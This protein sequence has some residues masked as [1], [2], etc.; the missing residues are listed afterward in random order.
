VVKPLPAG[1]I[2]DARRGFASDSQQDGTDMLSRTSLTIEGMASGTCVSDVTNALR[3]VPGVLTVQVEAATARAKVAH[4]PAVDIASLVAAVA[5][6]GYRAT[7]TADDVSCP[8]IGAVDSSRRRD[9][10]RRR[11]VAMVG[12]L[13]LPLAFL[14]VLAPNTASIH[15]VLFALM[16]PLWVIFFGLP[17]VGQRKR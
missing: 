15:W 11:L 6:V 5:R 12:Y 16:I 17:I 9:V 14:S 2:V 3:R 4:D 1:S 10:G 8:V 7:K 13:V